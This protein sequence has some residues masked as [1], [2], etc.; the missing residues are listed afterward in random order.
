MFQYWL[1]NTKIRGK[2][3]PIIARFHIAK[4]KVVVVVVLA[5]GNRTTLLVSLR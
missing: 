2:L 4:M 3:A 5:V 1:N